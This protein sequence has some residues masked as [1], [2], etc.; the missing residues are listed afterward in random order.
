M[1]LAEEYYKVKTDP[2]KNLCLGFGSKK[3]TKLHVR[4]E[5]LR[6]IVVDYYL[7]SNESFDCSDIPEAYIEPTK[8]PRFYPEKWS[9]EQKNS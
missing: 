3:D 8:I 7:A 9:N 2:L 5:R 6:K 4:K 1:F